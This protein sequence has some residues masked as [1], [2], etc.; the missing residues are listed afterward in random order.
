[1]G[2]LLFFLG[3]YSTGKTGFVFILERSGEKMEQGGA[4]LESTQRHY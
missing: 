1:M 4:K 2:H 3:F